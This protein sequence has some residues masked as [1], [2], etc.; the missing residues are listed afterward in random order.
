MKLTKL[1]LTSGFKVGATVR[2]AQLA[3]MVLA[4]GESTGGPDN[5]HVGADQWLY[6]K[7]GSGVAIVNG[8]QHQ[9]DPRSL[10]VIERGESH[11]I[12][13]TGSEPLS[14]INFYSPAAY[15]GNGDPLPAGKS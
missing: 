11:E 8:E 3:Q 14:T 10:L 9:L 5:R 7:S 12:R 6:V 4:P 15:D 2:D 13:A 1:T